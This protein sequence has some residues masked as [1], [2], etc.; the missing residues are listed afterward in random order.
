MRLLS[1]SMLMLLSW[2][3]MLTLLSA[4][5]EPL[6]HSSGQP[7][8]ADFSSVA[9]ASVQVPAGHSQQ[10]SISSSIDSCEPGAWPSREQLPFD[11]AHAHSKHEVSDT[12]QWTD[13]PVTTGELKSFVSVGIDV[14]ES[15]LVCERRA[16]G[17]ACV[18]SISG[19][20]GAC[21]GRHLKRAGA[22]DLV[23][24]VVSRDVDKGRVVKLDRLGDAEDV[25]T[26]IGIVGRPGK[27]FAA[28]MA[29][30]SPAAIFVGALP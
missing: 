3:S 22:L 8:N 17:G 23:D 15:T 18:T 9:L 6:G 1:S 29:A 21:A 27:V 16:R 24:S 26:S 30:L 7:V 19:K 13:A 10:Y 12:H 4:R 2:L 5:Y 20:S 25:V 11:C 14:S 28:V